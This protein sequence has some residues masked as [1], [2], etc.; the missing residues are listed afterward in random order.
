MKTVDEGSVQNSFWTSSICDDRTNL[1]KIQL[2][3]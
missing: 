3:Y 2:T 1:S